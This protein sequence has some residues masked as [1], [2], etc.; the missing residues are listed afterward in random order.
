MGLINTTIHF[1]FFFL[2]SAC[3]I[4]AKSLEDHTIIFRCWYTENEDFEIPRSIDAMQSNNTNVSP[5]FELF[6]LEAVKKDFLRM[7]QDKGDGSILWG[8]GTSVFNNEAGLWAE[9][10]LRMP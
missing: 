10:K 9:R 2:T 1:N 4:Q 5:A 8:K 7:V 3:N 6:A